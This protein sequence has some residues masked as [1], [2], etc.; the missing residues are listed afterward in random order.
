MK[1][2]SM[3]FRKTGNEISFESYFLGSKVKSI[4]NYITLKD[5]NAITRENNIANTQQKV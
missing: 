4:N 5:F 2:K 1:R 3:Y